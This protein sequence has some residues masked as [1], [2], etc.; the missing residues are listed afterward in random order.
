MEQNE[1]AQPIAL[2][3][4]YPVVI[5]LRLHMKHGSP[6]DFRDNLSKI[7][8]IIYIITVPDKHFSFAKRAVQYHATYCLFR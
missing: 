5:A 8:T 4:L 3:N 2:W 1:R 7:D 6:Y